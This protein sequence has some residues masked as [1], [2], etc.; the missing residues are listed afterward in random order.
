MS[1]IN[2]IKTSFNLNDIETYKLEKCVNHYA[3]A[4]TVK[5]LFFR[6]WNAVK[7]LF[8]SSEWQVIKRILESHSVT[9]IN[10]NYQIDE[11]ET[12]QKLPD[13]SKILS[14]HVLSL[15]I[16]KQCDIIHSHHHIDIYAL[17]NVQQEKLGHTR[18]LKITDKGLYNPGPFT[19]M[20][21]Q[22]L[23]S[24]LKGLAHQL[25]LSSDQQLANQQQFNQLI[26]QLDPWVAEVNIYE[27]DD[28]DEYRH[29]LTA[30]EKIIEFFINKDRT[31]LEL[32]YL[33]LSTL[34]NIFQI[35]DFTTRLKILDLSS[36]ELTALPPEIGQ[37]SALER[38][39]LRENPDITGIPLEILNLSQHC[40]IY[41]E[42]CGLSQAVL[43]NL[44]NV[45][46]HADYNGP[47]V[48]FSMGY[49]NPHEQVKSVEE[50]LES[51]F[52]IV[53]KEYKAFPNITKTVDE[54]HLK[55][56]VDEPI[57]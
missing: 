53:N 31:G 48:C 54:A 1:E 41:L 23:L 2:N 5:N 20:F 30:R 17:V 27:N 26:Q 50:S 35:G 55:A 4:N 12:Y 10:S 52:K 57:P 15:L 28:D 39:N 8:G 42:G 16:N 13:L 44:G 3:E 46:N 37:L 19:L 29:R 43:N 49:V 40:N 24:S 7:S 45:I 51:L 56:K 25:L 21:T 22:Y 47:R 11:N 14:E 38:L 9:I 33:D 18:L 6:I 36:N 32:Y 34:P